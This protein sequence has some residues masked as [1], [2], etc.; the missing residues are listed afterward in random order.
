MPLAWLFI[1]SWA[2][3]KEGI[4]SSFLVNRKDQY[5]QTCFLL[6][7][8]I[9]METLFPEWWNAELVTEHHTQARLNPEGGGCGGTQEAFGI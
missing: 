2:Y 8:D 5:S 4:R 9:Q 3:N 1:C 6:V 7:M